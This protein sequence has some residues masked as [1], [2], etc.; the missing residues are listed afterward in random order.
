MPSQIARTDGHFQAENYTLSGSHK[1]LV[2]QWKGMGMKYGEPVGT[3]A[4]GSLS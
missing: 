1:Y 2:P 3:S 4:D